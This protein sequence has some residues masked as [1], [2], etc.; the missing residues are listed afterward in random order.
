MK[1]NLLIPKSLSIIHNFFNVFVSLGHSVTLIDHNSLL[2]NSLSM[3]HE[4]IFRFPNVIK[5]QWHGYYFKQI[6]YSYMRL[7]DENPADLF[8][9]YNSQMLTP[10]IVKYIKSKGSKIF[11]FMGDSPYY[12]RTNQYYLNVLF[13]ADFIFSPDTHWI[14]QLKML[15]IK[16]ID[17]LV[18]GFNP[19]V[20]KKLNTTQDEI[21]KY[22]VNCVF[23]GLNY[24]SLLGFKRSFFLSKFAPHG[25]RIY[26]DKNWIRW[27]ERFPELE[28]CLKLKERFISDEEWNL[29]CNCAKIHPID[30]NPGLTNGIHIR[31]FDSIGSGILPIAEYRKDMDFVFPHGMLPYVKTYDEIGNLTAYY[32]SDDEARKQKIDELR[33]HVL[34][35]YSN[36]KACEQILSV[37]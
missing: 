12:T 15:G 17:Y 11:F 26:G 22:G 32:L 35:N 2:N 30:A 5:K 27:V 24:D 16:N 31:V 25:L 37:I 9:V 7:I 3:I 13:E 8:M 23:M 10:E 36:V 20:F 19:E 18:P 33:S 29:I 34:K 4:Q 28:P 6:H 21:E 1:I 14:E